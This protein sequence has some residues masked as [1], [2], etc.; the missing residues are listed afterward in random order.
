MVET[1]ATWTTQGNYFSFRIWGSVAPVVAV[2]MSFPVWSCRVFIQNNV[3]TENFSDALPQVSFLEMKFPFNF[4]P[5][6]ASRLNI[7]SLGAWCSFSLLSISFRT[8]P[9]SLTIDTLNSSSIN[10]QK[11]HGCMR[12][13]KTSVKPASTIVEWSCRLGFSEHLL[14]DMAFHA[15]LVIIFLNINL[16]ACAWDIPNETWILGLYDDLVC[17]LSSPGYVILPNST[18]RWLFIQPVWATARCPRTRPT[19]DRVFPVWWSL[20][21]YQSPISLHPVPWLD[22]NPRTWGVFESRCAGSGSD[23]LCY[24]IRYVISSFELPLLSEHIVLS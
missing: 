18:S 6:Y 19:L 9:S 1:S 16:D 15:R 5:R 22:E 2:R 21:V 13:S 8:L 14:H 24:T 12:M 20:F 10:P 4:T 17:S 7:R 23:W 3:G 11:S